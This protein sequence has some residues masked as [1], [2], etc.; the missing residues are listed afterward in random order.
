MQPSYLHLGCGQIKFENFCNI[1]LLPTADLQIN[2]NSGLPF[3]DDSIAGVYSEHFIEHLSQREIIRLLRE[4]RRILKLGGRA[5]FATPD[6]DILIA[7][8]YE[9]RW[10]QPWLE[11]YGYEWISSRAEYINISMREWGHQYLLNEDELIRLGKLAGFDTAIRC[12]PGVSDDYILC[13]RETRT[14]SSLIIEF[15]KTHPSHC[16]TP[17]VSITIPAYRPDFFEDSLKSAINQDY[18][19]IEI[20]VGDDSSSND[21]ELICQQAIKNGAPIRYQRNSHP[22]GEVDNFTNLIKWATGEFIKPLHDD[23]ILE[24]DAISR[25]LSAFQIAP[26]IKLAS[27]KRYPINGQGQVL[28]KHAFGSRFGNHDAVFRGSGIAG[29]MLSEGINYIGEPTCMLFRRTDVLA[30]EEPNVMSLFGRTCLGAGDVCLAT[31]LLSRGDLA[32]VASFVA[33]VRHHPGQT[34]AQP[35]HLERGKATWQYLRQQ[36]VRIGLLTE[37][38][39]PDQPIQELGTATHASHTQSSLRVT[40]GLITY[41]QEAYVGQAIES[42]F[43][44]TYPIDKLVICDDHSTDGTW[45]QIEATV[46]RCQNDSHNIREVIIHRNPENQGYLR[47]FQNAVKMAGGD[48]FIYQAGDDIALPHRVEKLVQAYQNAGRPEYAL[49]HS[50]TYVDR[51]DSQR[52]WS[53]PVIQLATKKDCI[54]A[55]ALHIGAT[56]AFTPN[57]LLEIGEIEVRTYDDLILGAR[58]AMLDRL[59]Y[60]DEPLLIY[61]SGGMTSGRTLIANPDLDRSHTENTLL[62]RWKDAHVLGIQDAISWLEQRL[63]QLGVVLPEPPP[64]LTKSVLSVNSARTI[65]S[66]ES[67]TAQINQKNRR[68]LVITAASPISALHASRIGRLDMARRSG[69]ELDI[70][71]WRPGDAIPNLNSFDWIWVFQIPLGENSSAIYQAL[72]TYK[73]TVVWETSGWPDETSID[74]DGSV[75]IRTVLA[76]RLLARCS[77]AIASHPALAQ[78]LK[79]RGAAATLVMRDALPSTWWPNLITTPS[80]LLPNRAQNAISIGIRADD[81]GSA[82]WGFVEEILW[83]LV[84]RLPTVTIQVWGSPPDTLRGIPRVSVAS[85]PVHDSKWSQRLANNPVDIALMPMLRGRTHLGHS[86]DRLWLEWTAAGAVVVGSEEGHLDD[87]RAHGLVIT[88][89][90]QVETWVRAVI[91]IATDGPRR[92]DLIERARDH[93]RRH[94]CLSS[95][96][97][98]DMT[99]LNQVLPSPL[100]LRLPD[101]PHAS[102]PAPPTDVAR[103]ID[104]EDYR[105]WCRSRE[106]REVDGETLAERVA[107]WGKMPEV[108]F[109]SLASS[110]QDMAALAITASS[111][112]SQLYPGWRWLVVSDQPCPDP[113]FESEPQ[114]AWWTLPTLDDPTAL[115]NAVQQAQKTWASEWMCIIVPGTFVHAQASI[116]VIDLGETHPGVQ[117]IF[118]DH[119]LWDETEPVGAEP[120]TSEWIARRRREPAFKPGLDILWLAQAD[121]IGPTVWLR[122]SSLEKHPLGIFPGAWWYGALLNRYADSPSAVAHIPQVLSTLPQHTTRELET[123]ARPARQTCLEVLQAKLF[124]NL[125]VDISA[126]LNPRTLQVRPLLP[127]TAISVVLVLQNVHFQCREAIEA[128]QAQQLNGDEVEFIVVAH[129]ISDPD[130]NKLLEEW[131]KRSTCQVLHD[132]GSYELGRLYNAGANLARYDTLVFLHA[133]VIPIDPLMLGRLA[134]ALA[135]PE[136]GIAAPILFRPETA[137]IDSAGLAPGGSSSW[138]LAHTLGAPFALLDDGPWDVFRVVRSVPAVEPVAFAMRRSTWEYLNGFDGKQIHEHAF[139]IDAALRL[140]QQGRRTIVTPYARAAHQRGACASRL[141]PS[142][143]EQLQKQVQ[144][145]ESAEDL[146]LRW[147]RAWADHDTWPQSLSLRSDGW[148]LD[149][150]APIRWPLYRPL[151]PRTLGYSVSGGSGR[152]RV[153]SPLEALAQSGRQYTEVMEANTA[154]LTPP[155]LLRLQPDQ[156]LLHQWLG[157]AT[158]E[159]IQSW[160]KVKPSLRVI[161]GLDDRNDALPEKSSLY[162]LHRRAHPDARAKLRRVVEHCDAVIVSTPP[163]QEMLE[164]LGLAQ[165][166][167]HVIPNALSRDRWGNLRAPR[168]YR[169]RPRVG[170][171]GAMQHR[172]DLEFL[173]PVIRATRDCVDWVFMGMVLPEVRAEIKEF[174]RWVPY[175]RYPAAIAALDLDLAVAPLE[176]NIFNEC[177]SNLR[178][179]EYGAASY[180]VICT[181]IVPYREQN[182]PVIHLDNQ[183]DLWIDAIRTAVSDIDGLR[184][185]GQA[186]H[187]WVWQHYDL[188]HHLPHWDQALTGG[189]KRPHGMHPQG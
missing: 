104:D 168:N 53:P 147:G 121:Y 87:A 38:F 41:N 160:R 52:I 162:G 82:E 20:C 133:D 138:Q 75:A 174:H 54:T 55:L 166:P 11:K 132:R 169:T 180:P 5:R 46:A 22:L 144:I 122:A 178:L 171:I 69:A 181:D 148:Q 27:G 167:V 129:Q 159:A 92:L 43:K 183:T 140:R 83:T 102:E 26:S 42:L 33:G 100:R 120:V 60:I 117:A 15:I 78:L 179:L 134:R 126:G 184:K 8:V 114:L 91:D 12:A 107:R 31:Q 37:Q 62:Q 74:T 68:I 88:T 1:D 135:L 70:H 25:L 127:P 45:T 28:N 99:A 49:I 164:E 188:E 44:Q 161:M 2:I 16:V 136:V 72:D 71:W 67:T 139:I 77:V 9:N 130:T 176:R 119:D 21:I 18:P 6:L 23:D 50:S 149:E 29:T 65:T 76:R 19:Y 13:N 93:V 56:E 14:E 163:L 47:N 63:T 17:L 153:K 109:V 123:L 172:G 96:W 48:F 7:E 173:I 57:L 32:Y 101:N 39:T 137:G 84:H 118:H 97:L 157:P 85:E 182:A 170:W 155:E 112:G 151:R 24:P 10:K 40:V 98:N 177:K 189:N 51:I 116:E 30:L 58:A 152:Y 61:R 81:F 73:S 128:L 187:D 80:H 115:P 111:L 150:L 66:A 143:F 156:I 131:S 64:R 3:Q 185:C 142:K 110:P 103:I 106:L 124:P 158:V 89:N 108:M 113:L 125:D 146:W 35:H 94:R 95:Q 79:Q 165:T 175:D 186:L 36:A 141:Y 86:G 90:N 34:Q 105:A 154:L 4:C 59:I 145:L